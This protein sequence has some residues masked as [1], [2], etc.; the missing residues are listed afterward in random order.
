MSLIQTALEEYADENNGHY[1]GSL[2]AVNQ[3]GETLKDYLL[4]I[5]SEILYENCPIIFNP[6]GLNGILRP[7]PDKIPE[8][9]I[10]VYTDAS[11][12]FAADGSIYSIFG[13][14]KGGRILESGMVSRNEGLVKRYR[15]THQGVPLIFDL[16]FTIISRW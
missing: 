13:G 12:S 11:D 5:H 7:A 4:F 6:S 1:P 16:C 8:G 2:S 9:E 15:G 3:G 14:G 10:W